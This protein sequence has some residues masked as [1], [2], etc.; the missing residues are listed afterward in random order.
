MPGGH[1]RALL[2]HHNERGLLL[3]K[4]PQLLPR[5]ID[6]VWGSLERLALPAVDTLGTRL[7]PAPLTVSA[8]VILDTPVRLTLARVALGARTKGVNT[9]YSAGSTPPAPL[10]HTR[11]GE[12]GAPDSM[13]VEARRPDKTR[14]AGRADLG[15]DT[16]DFMPESL[17]GNQGRLRSTESRQYSAGACRWG[18]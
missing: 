14:K 9:M 17:R 3:G 4:L 8:G 15:L 2:H 11:G 16:T 5:R 10:A 1:Y 7:T 12:P 6:S 13:E 18:H